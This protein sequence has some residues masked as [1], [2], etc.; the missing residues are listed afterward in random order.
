MAVEV[1]LGEQE[2]PV[3]RNKVGAVSFVNAVSLGKMV[4]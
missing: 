4:G 3:D 2:V 1:G